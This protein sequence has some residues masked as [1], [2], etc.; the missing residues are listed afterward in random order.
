MNIFV[1]GGFGYLGSKIAEYL[2]NEGNYV[3]VGTRN[4]TVV[5]SNNDKFYSE[6]S[7]IDWNN[8]KEIEALFENI[9]FI[10][11]T[12]GLSA[13][14]C[15]NDPS[16][17]LEVNAL[18]TS[19]IVEA[20]IRHRVK[21]F[22]YIST[23]HV[24]SDVLN[25]VISED[26][27]P[28]NI[29]PYAYSHKVAED[30]VCAAH[31]RGVTKGIVLRL[32]NGFG[33]P[34]YDSES[35][36]NLFVNDACKQSIINKKLVLRS[37]GLQRRNFIPV[38]E[39]CS[40]ISYMISNLSIVNDSDHA[41]LINVGSKESFTILGMAKLI[42]KQTCSLFGYSPPI[43]KQNEQNEQNEVEFDYRIDKLLSLGYK[44]KFT[45]DDEIKMLLKYCKY[46]LN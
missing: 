1:T 8:E 41:L 27:C 13:A 22:V 2:T 42:K 35:L 14:E 46:N 44:F 30:I 40:I 25:G 17:A 26:T 19:R 6:V 38:N 31:K 9:D 20:A 36:W 7:V 16:S 3:I 24:Y 32:S 12:A 15:A 37:D 29:H 21:A 45:I 11:H 34:T 10:I 5:N 23:V 43:L 28:I 18:Y 33:I 39:V 4:K